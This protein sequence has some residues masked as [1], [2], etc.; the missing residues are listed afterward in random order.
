[1]ILILT[2]QIRAIPKASLFLLNTAL[3][4]EKP[5]WND[6]AARYAKSEIPAI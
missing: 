2:G 4:D 5:A 6:I 1:L 3:F